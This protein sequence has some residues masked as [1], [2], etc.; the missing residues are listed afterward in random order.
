MHLTEQ[1]QWKESFPGTT[2]SRFSNCKAANHLPSEGNSV[3]REVVP[4]NHS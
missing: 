4:L 2:A 3:N 1:T